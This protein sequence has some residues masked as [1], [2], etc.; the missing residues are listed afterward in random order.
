METLTC[1]ISPQLSLYGKIEK[2]IAVT[3]FVVNETLITGTIETIETPSEY[4]GSYEVTPMVNGQI[5]DT[6]NKM[7]V[8][9]LQIM[10][11]PYSEV[12]N[13]SG[14]KTVTIG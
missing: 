7:M 8:Q 2:F 9:D 10:D 1:Y 12:I 4:E 13:P 6:N 14:G 3:G 5:L 11:I